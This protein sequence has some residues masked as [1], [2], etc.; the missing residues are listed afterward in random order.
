MPWIIAALISLVLFHPAEFTIGGGKP[1]IV[2]EGTTIWLSQDVT[3]AGFRQLAGLTKLKLLYLAKT[4]VGDSG[5]KVI[6]NFM[7][8]EHLKLNETSITDTGLLELRVLKNLK[9]LDV[10]HT[11]ASA[12]AVEQLDRSLPNVQIRFR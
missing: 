5:M 1:R 7:Q 9:S 11:K 8:L 12:A 2:K 10:Y 6:A 4:K 3:D